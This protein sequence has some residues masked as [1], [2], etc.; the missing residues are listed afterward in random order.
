MEK[1]S[2][3]RFLRDFG[4][5]DAA[6]E[7]NR[8]LMELHQIAVDRM[9]EDHAVD[10]AYYKAHEIASRAEIAAQDKRIRNLYLCL[11][12]AALAAAWAVVRASKY[13]C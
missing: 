11:F 10:L 8:S 9:R 6:A 4:I 13:G 5:R 12:I 3:E 1:T 7:S 2:D